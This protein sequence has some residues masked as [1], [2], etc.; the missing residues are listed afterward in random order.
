MWKDGQGTGPHGGTQGV[1]EVGAAPN[2][3][4]LEKLKAKSQT[5]KQN[6]QEVKQNKNPN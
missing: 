6:N 4:F 5:K 2:K 1:A 3:S